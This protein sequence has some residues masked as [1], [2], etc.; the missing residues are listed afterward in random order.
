MIFSH[1]SR[2]G[3]L[4]FPKAFESVNRSSLSTWILW[5]WILR[6]RYIGEIRRVRC[7]GRRSW[8]DVES[9]AK[10]SRNW[11]ASCESVEELLQHG[12]I[13]YN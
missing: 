8:V 4:S 9:A 11:K 7:N 6:R 13:L 12:K 5:S 3:G 2:I 1:L 10:R